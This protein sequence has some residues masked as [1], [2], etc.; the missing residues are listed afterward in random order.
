MLL[1]LFMF[2]CSLNLVD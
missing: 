2:G 1:P